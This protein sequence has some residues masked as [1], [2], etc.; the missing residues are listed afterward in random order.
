M[1]LHWSLF[2]VGLVL[3]GTTI[4]VFP[5]AKADVCNQKRNPTPKLTSLMLTFQMP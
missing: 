3:A 2:K 1:I 5:Q 4:L